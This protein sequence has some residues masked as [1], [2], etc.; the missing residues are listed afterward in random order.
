MKTITAFS[1]LS[2]TICT[3]LFTSLS[4]QTLVEH[5]YTFSKAY[6]G[7]REGVTGRILLNISKSYPDTTSH[8]I[9]V[10]LSNTEPDTLNSDLILKFNASVTLTP[11]DLQKLSEEISFIDSLITNNYELRTFSSG[12]GGITFGTGINMDLLE[13]FHYV[14]SADVFIYMRKEDFKELVAVFDEANGVVQK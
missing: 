8:I 1:I 12:V 2:F 5:L 14:K 3:I 11:Y 4:A 9:S 10:E 13:L 6:S 7:V